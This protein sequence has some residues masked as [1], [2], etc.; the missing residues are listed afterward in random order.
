MPDLPLRTLPVSFGPAAH[1]MRAG[2]NHLGDRLIV[3][4]AEDCLERWGVLGISTARF[5]GDDWTVL[6]QERRWKATEIWWR[7]DYAAVTARFKMLPTFREPHWTLVLPDLAPA[8]LDALRLLFDEVRNPC[9]PPPDTQPAPGVLMLHTGGLLADRPARTRTEV[10]PVTTVTLTA[11]MATFD[12][13]DDR[14]VSG[15][16]AWT[17]PTPLVRPGMRVQ[18]VDDGFLPSPATIMTV[19]NGRF[20]ARLDD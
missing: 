9:W 2:V 4:D 19:V 7:A 15:R 17:T 13:D 18:V 1:V 3:R 6:A 8:T 11:A 16:L 10:R 14:I 20:T 5:D 12:E